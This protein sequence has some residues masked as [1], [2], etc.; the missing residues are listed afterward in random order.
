MTRFAISGFL[1]SV[2]LLGFAVVTEAE[3]LRVLC[4][5]I[6]HGE[7]TDGELE[8][9]RIARVIRSENPDVAALQ[10]VDQNTQRTGNVDQPAELAR[11]TAMQVVFGKN[12]GF[13]G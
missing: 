1:A 8:L 10:E 5:N 3:P 13:E 12:I 7:G 4:Y 2:W 6:H 11:L 9:E